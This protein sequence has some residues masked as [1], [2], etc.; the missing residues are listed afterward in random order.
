VYHV[1]NG[2]NH[3]SMSQKGC[4]I[5]TKN[6]QN[7]K[8]IYVLSFKTMDIMASCFFFIHMN[9]KGFKPKIKLVKNFNLSFDLGTL[10]V[11]TYCVRRNQFC[12]T[13]K[14]FINKKIYFDAK[15]SKRI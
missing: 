13:I 15:K 1:V 4:E 12:R 9:V 14:K 11:N 8:N 5:A 2:C 7:W 6:I 3:D 10:K